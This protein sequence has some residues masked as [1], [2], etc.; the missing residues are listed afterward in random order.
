MST[1][2]QRLDRDALAAQAVEATGLEDFGEPSW[3]ESLDR[4]L[5]DLRTEAR[6]SEIGVEVVA[7]EVFEYLSNR[8]GIVGYGSEHPEVAAAPINRPIVIVGQPRTGTTILYDLLAQD[9]GLR[10]PLTW[11]VDTPVPPPEP[12]TYETD[13]RIEASQARLDMASTL[14]PDLLAFH[15]MGARLAQECVRITAGDFRSMIFPTQYRVPHYDRWLL[16][17]ADMAPAYR[18]HRRF[19]QH[20]QANELPQQWLVKS[21]A[22]LWHL[23]A[24]LGEY[25]DATIIVTH[26]DPLKVI[27]SVTALTAVLRRL[28]SDEISLPEIAAGFAHDIFLGLDRLMAACDAGVVPSRQMINVQFEAFVRDPMATVESVYAQL[29]RELTGATRRRME[30]FLESHPGDGGGAGSRY[31]FGDTELDAEELRER[32]AAYQDRFGV[33]SEPVR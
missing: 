6:L 32:S 28:A 3:Q 9:P 18:W 26:R 30:D 5:E 21:P 22:H 13:P 8:L 27:A 1:A 10:V 12:A 25:H 2:A 20:L 4:L 33:N 16:D 14:V 24:L 7:L 29:D 11:E 15:P 31:S 23:G 17:E 19:L